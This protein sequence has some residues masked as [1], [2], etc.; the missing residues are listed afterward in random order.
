MSLRHP[1]DADEGEQFR[2]DMV[3]QLEDLDRGPFSEREK[4]ALRFVEKFN[5]D[6]LGIDDAYL[7]GLRQHFNDAEIVELAQV[8]GAYLFRHRLNEVL[9]LRQTGCAAVP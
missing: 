4:A 6:H 5:Y 8:T 7:D 9:G 1:W 3:Q 2:E